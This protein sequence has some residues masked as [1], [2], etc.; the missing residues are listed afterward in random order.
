MINLLLLNF[1]Q[2]CANPNNIAAKGCY[3]FKRPAFCNLAF[4]I[5]FGICIVSHL[6]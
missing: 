2:I 1:R 3:H 5:C 4:S 6:L